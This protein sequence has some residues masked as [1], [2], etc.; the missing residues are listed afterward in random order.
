[1]QIRRKIAS[2]MSNVVAQLHCVSQNNETRY[3]IKTK[4][5]LLVELPINSV[6]EYVSKNFFGSDSEVSSNMRKSLQ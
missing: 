1:M 4:E 2:I 5:K 6:E 3:V